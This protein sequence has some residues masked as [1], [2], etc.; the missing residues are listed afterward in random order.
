[1]HSFRI[2]GIHRKDR[3][4]GS[5]Q[6]RARSVGAGFNLRRRKSGRSRFKACK[7]DRTG[8]VIFNAGLQFIELRRFGFRIASSPYRRNIIERFKFHYGRLRL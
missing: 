5:I 7:I 3:F 1:M 4:H 8:L 2:G 6:S